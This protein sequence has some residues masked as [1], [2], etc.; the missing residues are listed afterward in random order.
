MEPTVPSRPK[1]IR[2]IGTARL[3][4]HAQRRLS[5]ARRPASPAPSCGL[6]YYTVGTNQYF[7]TIA[8]G[9]TSVPA[10][11]SL[12]YLRYVG[13]CPLWALWIVR[14]CSRSR[15]PGPLPARGDCLVDKA[16]STIISLLI[17]SCDYRT[18]TVFLSTPMCTLY[19][20]YW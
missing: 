18:C 8:H 20:T 3:Q 15:R 10:Y 14:G 17:S 11:S 16:T 19:S 1:G 4:S 12:Q 13:P 7:T 9:Y 6:K 2:H 5:E